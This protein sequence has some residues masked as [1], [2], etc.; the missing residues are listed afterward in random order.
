MELLEKA[1][2]LQGGKS[3]NVN[4]VLFGAECIKDGRLAQFEHRAA[5]AE[6]RPILEHECGVALGSS[7]CV[8]NSFLTTCA[9]IPGR[10]RSRVYVLA[11]ES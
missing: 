1:V 11:F 6:A 3:D 2:D 9:A 8:Q 4:L 7:T 5:N 10:A